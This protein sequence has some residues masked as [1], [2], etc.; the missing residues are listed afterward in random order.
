MSELDEIRRRI[1]AFR[2]E[3]DWM[4]FHSP[5]NLACSIVIEA[6]ELLEHFQWKT[7]EQSESAALEKREEIAE[8]IADVAIYLIELADNLGINLGEAIHAKIARNEAK[9]PV[10]KARGSAK[11][12]TE[13]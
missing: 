7:P 8:E 10:E 6:A 9:Y 1:Q 11:K 12:Y 2:D 13:L 3:R 5:K 4:Q